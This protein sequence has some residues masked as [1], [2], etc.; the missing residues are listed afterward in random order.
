M[1][2]HHCD[3]TQSAT[4]STVLFTI[5]SSFFFIEEETKR[6][7]TLSLSYRRG[8]IMIHS[9]CYMPNKRDFMIDKQIARNTPNAYQTPL[10]FNATQTI[11]SFQVIMKNWM[12]F[13][14]YGEPLMPLIIS[15]VYNLFLPNI[16]YLPL[17]L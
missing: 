4:F 2:K 1:Y 12:N 5:F 8:Q 17:Y 15:L 6:E 9:H 10:P 3:E 14:Q 16:L 11:Q 13:S 7:R